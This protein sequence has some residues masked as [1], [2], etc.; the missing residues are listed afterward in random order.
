MILSNR[1]INWKEKAMIRWH[2]FGKFG[3]QKL[4]IIS[5]T[6]KEETFFKQ[7]VLQEGIRL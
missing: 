1:K 2:Y 7:I 5:F 6:F 4:D 3:E